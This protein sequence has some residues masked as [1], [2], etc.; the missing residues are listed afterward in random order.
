MTCPSCGTVAADG[1]AFCEHCG[2]ALGAAAPAPAAV[3]AEPEPPATPV[4]RSCGGTIAADGYCE[5]CGELAVSARD[6]WA[7]LPSPLVGGVCDRGRRKSRNEDAMALAVVGT[8][9]VLVV[10]DGVSNIQ[11][12]DVASLAAARAARDVLVTGEPQTVAAWSALL[13]ESAAAAD[14]AIADAVGDLTGRVEPPS[15]T[16]VAAVVDGPTVVAGWLGDSRAYWI[17]DEGAAHQVSV[18]DSAAN[19]MIARGIPRARAEASRE[20][21]AITRWLGPD[22]ETVVPSTGTTRA[23][24]PGWVF[25]CSDG[26]WNYCSEADDVADLLHRTIEQ[27]GTSPDT[28]CAEL[29]R[30]A[31]AAGGHDNITASLARVAAPFD[32]VQ[33]EETAPAPPASPAA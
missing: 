33:T 12:S 23:Q 26:L 20:G 25:V 31:N 27:V 21:H 7:E 18:D 17:P 3:L 13:V 30:W 8:T 10:C 5:H 14:K 19:E 29:V 9:A 6:H 11:D 15:C 22:A 32:T 16:F 24:G 4:C 1:S 28:I 2:T